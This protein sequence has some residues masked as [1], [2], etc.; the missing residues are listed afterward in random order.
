MNPYLDVS[1]IVPTYREQANIAEL[2]QRLFGALKKSHLSAELIIVDDNSKDGTSE[3]CDELAKTYPVRL[4]IRRNQRGLA[5]AVVNGFRAARG[6]FLVV[7]DADLSHPPEHV[8]E[9]VAPLRGDRA[10]FVF[11]S[12][13]V[14]GGALHSSW[15]LF[16]W[17]NSRVAGLL[18][19]GLT[20]AKDP[21]AGFFAIGLDT[22]GNPNALNP[23]GYKI[24]LEVLVRCGCRR[25]VEVPIH[26]A[27]RK[28]GDSKLTLREQ[29]LY[30]RHLRR[31]YEFR[32]P[33]APRFAKFAAVGFSGMMVDVLSFRALLSVLGLPAG[34]ALSI[35]IAMTW[36]FALNRGVT[37]KESSD[38]HSVGEYLRFCA[39]CLVGAGLSWSTSLTLMHS[40]NFFRNRPVAAAVFGTVVAAVAN[41]ALCRRWVFGRQSSSRTEMSADRLLATPEFP[42]VELVPARAGQPDAD[43]LR[44]RLLPPPEG[45]VEW[46][47]HESPDRRAA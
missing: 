33:E 28:H 32:F 10:D 30:V 27:E 35:W 18:A 47:L 41:Y 37:F 13:Y 23:C 11:G 17:L 25:V 16:R 24:G 21:M 3:L 36:N 6:R 44:V 38:R 42:D 31:L 8:P 45:H 9:L 26:F 2:C 19:A 5:T 40:T 14:D 4:M 46:S 29:W 34:R 1:V 7:M 15:G 12:R 22:L 20:R 39:A 43:P